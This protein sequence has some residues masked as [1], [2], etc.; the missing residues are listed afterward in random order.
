MLIKNLIILLF[1]GIIFW[2]LMA[3]GFFP[4]DDNDAASGRRGE[5]QAQ[6]SHS[7]VTAST[8][9]GTILLLLAVGV[10]GALG[11]SRTKK[12][13]ESKPHHNPTDH[14][15]QHPNVKEDR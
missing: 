15:I 1:A 2:G 11:I 13:S 6:T 10:I 12:S 5:N 3:G 8:S 14:S 4:S 7:Y 9:K